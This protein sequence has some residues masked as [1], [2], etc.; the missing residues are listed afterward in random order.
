MHMNVKQ[1]RR[2]EGMQQWKQQNRYKRLKRKNLSQFIALSIGVETSRRTV[3]R[4]PNSL[5]IDAS[6]ILWVDQ[7]Q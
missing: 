7:S 3:Q 5:R 1:L 4:G 6:V 2:R